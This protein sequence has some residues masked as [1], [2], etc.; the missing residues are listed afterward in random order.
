MMAA[1]QS[2]KNK[3]LED[4]YKYPWFFGELSE[5]NAKEI[6][7]EAKQNDENCSEFSERKT[8]LFLRT[9]FDDIKKNYFTIAMGYLVQHDD[10]N[11]EPRFYFYKDYSVISPMLSCNKNLVMRKNPF[12]LEELG[13]VK[14]QPLG[15]TQRL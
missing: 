1:S 8:I 14:L 15:S 13:K 4:L 12:S 6:L 5:E 10:F 9:G 3:N 2:R 7:V 11:G